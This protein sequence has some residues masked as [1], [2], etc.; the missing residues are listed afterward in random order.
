[1]Y[2]G[3]CWLPSR[4]ATSRMPSGASA[5]FLHHR[6]EVAQPKMGPQ[7]NLA[8]A[9]NNKSEREKER[10]ERKTKS[11][12]E[13]ITGVL[14]GPLQPISASWPIGKR[15][16]DPHSG[17][18][19]AARHLLSAHLEE[20][21]PRAQGTDVFCAF[22]RW[23][24]A[25]PKKVVEHLLPLVPLQCSNLSSQYD[26]MRLLRPSVRCSPSV[27][28]FSAVHIWFSILCCVVLFFPFLVPSTQLTAP[29]QKKNRLICQGPGASP[30]GLCS[31]FLIRKGLV[32]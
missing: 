12:D 32:S 16:V 31:S 29:R 9:S 4:Y 3:T 25:Q 30:A 7:K 10:E 17:T 11:G 13:I 6:G 5:R 27:P 23:P 14:R 1:M 21:T 24:R 20:G 18:P 19:C 22:V 26:K 8:P 28:S 15:W 2:S